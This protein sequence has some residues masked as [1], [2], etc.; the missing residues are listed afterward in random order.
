MQA[1]AQ[2]RDLSGF[3]CCVFNHVPSDPLS[4]RSEELD[5]LYRT[6][7]LLE[8]LSDGMEL[9]TDNLRFCFSKISKA[10]K[11]CLMNMAGSGVFCVWPAALCT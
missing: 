6:V 10:F 11:S 9:G 5:V 8:L 3:S 4:S 7:C 2:P 1:R